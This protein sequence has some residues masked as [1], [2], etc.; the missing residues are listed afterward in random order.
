MGNMPDKKRSPGAAM[1]SGGNE[2]GTLMGSGCGHVGDRGILGLCFLRGST[3]RPY[4]ETARV[5]N[6]IVAVI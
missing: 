3:W 5:W 2:P 6:R 4:K 1:G